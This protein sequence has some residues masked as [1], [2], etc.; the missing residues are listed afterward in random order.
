MPGAH[1][2]SSAP[3]ADWAVPSGAEHGAP[4]HHQ[5][6][7]G[8]SSSILLLPGAAGSWG[9]ARFLKV[10]RYRCAIKEGRN[11]PAPPPPGGG[12]GWPLCCVRLVAPTTVPLITS[13]LPYDTQMHGSRLPGHTAP[14]ILN[15]TLTNMLGP[16][17]NRMACAYTHHHHIIYSN[18]FSVSL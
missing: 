6:G 2:P 9:P 11:N 3:L 5:L 12:G 1:G 10:A 14:W 7:G 4:R 13:N 16:T 18:N 15:F 17:G 8:G